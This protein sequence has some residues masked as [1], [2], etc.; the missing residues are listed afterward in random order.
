MGPVGR[1]AQP[2]DLQAKRPQYPPGKDFSMSR[3][4]RR[5]MQRERSAQ[6]IARANRFSLA[7][8]PVAVGLYLADNPNR[9]KR[10]AARLAFMEGF[11]A[12]LERAQSTA[13]S[14]LTVSTPVRDSRGRRN[15][16]MG[17]TSY[18]V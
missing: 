12:E 17:A 11:I 6:R 7:H 15:P 13:Y 16:R 18:T 2:P 8:D 10:G 5:R 9:V 14:P 1:I 3:S 4:A